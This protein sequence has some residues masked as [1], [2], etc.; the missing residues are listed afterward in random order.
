[1]KINKIL[2]TFLATYILTLS[3]CFSSEPASNEL[4]LQD[5]ALPSEVKDIAKQQGSIYYDTSTKNKA[6]VPT[7]LWGEIQRP[8]LHFIPTDTSLIKGLSLAGGPTGAAKLEEIILTRLNPDGSIRQYE[9]NLRDGG[10]AK[11][12][13]FKLESGD[14]IFLRKDTFY[15]NRNYYTSWISIA[16][17]LIT[18]F[19]IVTKVK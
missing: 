15:E 1:M 13:T 12:H 18:T 10:D 14:S 7:H 16:L 6:L 2:C 9:F 4:S 17:S 3:V 5:I 11:A 19:F 8:G